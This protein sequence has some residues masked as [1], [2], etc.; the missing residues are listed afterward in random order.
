MNRPYPLLLKPVLKSYLWGGDRLKKEFG[1]DAGETITAQ[2]WM[3]AC[4]KDGSNIVRNG[5]LAGQ[6]LPGVLQNGAMRA[7]HSDQIDRRKAKA[8]TSGVSRSG[9]RP[10]V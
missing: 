3:L 2:S 9:L 6:T 7:A 5:A 8:V 4:H 1:F 10:H